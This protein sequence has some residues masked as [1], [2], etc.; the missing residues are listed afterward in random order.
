MKESIIYRISHIYRDDFRIRAFTFGHG[1]KSL[2]I[3]R[4]EEHTSELQ[5]RI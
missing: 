5:S 3:V 2:C 1:E 4:S